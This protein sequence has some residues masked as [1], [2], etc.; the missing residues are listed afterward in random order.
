MSL[1]C[2]AIVERSRDLAQ[3]SLRLGDVAQNPRLPK[4]CRYRAAVMADQALELGVQFEALLGEI[5]GR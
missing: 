1:S 3:L 2:E 4:P 5:R